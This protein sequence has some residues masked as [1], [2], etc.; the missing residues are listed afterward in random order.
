MTQTDPGITERRLASLMR[1]FRH[2]NFRLFFSGQMV[3]L[4]GTWMQSVAQSWLVY[5]LT[6][7]ALLLGT[8]AFLGQFPVLVFAPAGGI[9]A[10][11][12]RRHGVVITTQVVSMILAFALAALT[13]TGT[14]RVWHVGVLAALGGVV[15]AF[16]IPARQAFIVEMVG[17]D[18]MPNAIALNSSMFNGARI[19]GPAIAGV[20]VAAIG[21]G[22]C[23]LVN[24]LSFLGVI[25]GLLM[26]RL[27]ARAPS[28][29]L[30]SPVRDVLDGFRFAWKT[31]PIRALL[32]LIGIVSLCGMP[33]TI[34]MPIFAD[35]VLNGGPRALGLLMGA[36]GVGAL[37]GALSLAARSSVRGLGRWVAWAGVSFGATL[38]LFSISRV[39]LLSEAALVLVGF[40]MMLQMASSNTL[41]QSMAPDRL[42][43]RMMA[44]YSMMFMGMS[45]FGALLE[46]ALAHRLGAP[47]AV[48]AGGTVCVLAALFFW[49]RL[50]S[51]RVEARRLILAQG[52]AGG[53]PPDIVTGGGS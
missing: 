25:G 9:V 31:V 8:I 30:V 47:G 3:S 53:E 16:D 45:P 14:V 1:S 7:S 35:T 48:A 51:M 36:T 41:I 6:G 21:E 10:D 24:G 23:F 28:P 15:S 12:R 40:S 20:M 32:L 52:M 22:W 33:Y 46:G 44:L 19:L 11:R 29:S 49:T 4:I 50:P 43:G 27:E 2:R 26:M 37:A 18:D 13:L 39:L 34:L 42:R 5:R 17:S 38:I